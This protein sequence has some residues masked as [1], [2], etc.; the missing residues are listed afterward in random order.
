MP[1][2]PSSQSTRHSPPHTPDVPSSPE[3]TAVEEVASHP[4]TASFP[5]TLVASYEEGTE[6]KDPVPH[7]VDLKRDEYPPVSPGLAETILTL[8][9]LL[10]LDPAVSATI[11]ATAFGL[12]ST[13]RQRTADSAQKLQEAEHK[14]AR[15]KAINQ[16][17]QADNR[18]L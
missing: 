9:P 11:R 12:I 15:L 7:L 18:Q 5:L 16:Q 10:A 13:I 4:T 2:S 1:N 3:P 14:I 17:R 6:N 8:N